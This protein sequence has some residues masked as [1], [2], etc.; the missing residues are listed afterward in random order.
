MKT[1]SK[2]DIENLLDELYLICREPGRSCS[3]C[4]LE[5]DEK[6]KYDFGG[7]DKLDMCPLDV[8]LLEWKT[9]EGGR[10]KIHPWVYENIDLIYKRYQELK[11]E[12]EK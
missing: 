4:P 8:V 10:N 3:G 6:L 2:G 7:E 9:P 12:E 11:G 1:F 5:W